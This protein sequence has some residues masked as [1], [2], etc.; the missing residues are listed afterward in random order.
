M[1]I[2]LCPANY[3]Q[4]NEIFHKALLS[5]LGG[6]ST[7][8]LEVIKIKECLYFVKNVFYVTELIMYDLFTF[9]YFN[10]ADLIQ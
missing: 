10:S 5:V 6:S 4:L 9:Y 3:W 8:S 7:N 1:S 2:H